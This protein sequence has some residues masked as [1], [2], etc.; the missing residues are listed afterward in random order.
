MLKVGMAPGEYITI[1]DDIRIVFSGGTG[2]HI[3][4]LVDAPQDKRILRSSHPGVDEHRPYY[5]EEGLSKEHV[6]H[7]IRQQKREKRW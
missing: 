7:L 3:H 6:D 4:L 5:A 1:G 2:H